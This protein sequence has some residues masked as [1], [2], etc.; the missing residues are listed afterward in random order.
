MANSFYFNPVLDKDSIGYMAMAKYISSGNVDKA[1]QIRPEV[2]MLYQ[3]ILSLGIKIG[4]PLE[5]FGRFLSII[6][7]AFLTYLIFYIARFFLSDKFSLVSALLLICN[8]LLIDSNSA[9]L[10]DSF[11]LFVIALS[12]YF[13]LSAVKEFR[14]YKYLIAGIFAGISAQTRIAGLDV[15]VFFP[16]YICFS[17]IFFKKYDQMIFYRN[18]IIGFIIFIIAFLVITLPIQHYFASHGSIYTI[19]LGRKLLDIYLI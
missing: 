19:F 14:I 10:R 13:L 4:F 11:L 9:V 3:Y 8:P 15:V 1:C 5:L 2:P 17:F 18:T 16:L 12:L 6:C 7:G